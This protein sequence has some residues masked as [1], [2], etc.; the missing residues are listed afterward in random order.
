MYIDDF[1]MKRVVFL[2][3]AV[4][5]AAILMPSGVFAHDFK[6]GD[7]YYKIYSYKEGTVV[8]TYKGKGYPKK[9]SYPKLQAV[10]IPQT[11]TAKGK[12]YRVVGIDD[13][14]FRLCEKLVYAGLCEGL[15]FIGDH[16]FEHCGSMK[17]IDF[18]ESLR[19]IGN[20]VFVLSGLEQVS[21]PASATALGNGVF[22]N[23]EELK[24]VEFKERPL[25]FTNFTIP[26]SMF[27]GCH[28]LKEIK[29]DG[30]SMS[31]IRSKAFSGCDS[32]S[33]LPYSVFFEKCTKIG[34]YAFFRCT[35]IKGA[36]LGDELTEI[37]ESAFSGCLNLTEMYIPKSVKKIGLRAFENCS[38]LKEFWL[39]Y[40][41]FVA[42]TSLTGDFPTSDKTAYIGKIEAHLYENVYLAYGSDGKMLKEVCRLNY[43]RKA[44]D[45]YEDVVVCI[46]PNATVCVYAGGTITHAVDIQTYDYVPSY[47]RIHFYD[48]TNSNSLRVTPTSLEL[49][50][51]PLLEKFTATSQDVEI[52]KLTVKKIVDSFGLKES[53]DP[54]DDWWDWLW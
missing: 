24:S 41:T 49:S 40:K 12:T 8:V 47:N 28:K 6:A 50:Y 29:A 10:N 23:C 25:K 46:F 2:F 15:E 20:F 9:C 3:A 44:G 43:R 17:R 35:G 34:D 11:V 42:G 19:K 32:L 37:G 22:A 36:H 21:L 26:E 5:L 4:L 14:T 31:E 7:L 52:N 13:Y 16:A 54:E 33:V 30:M 51:G 53:E 39:S 48:E 1:S 18:P 38:R 27:I 45:G